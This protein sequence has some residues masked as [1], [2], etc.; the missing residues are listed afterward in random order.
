MFSGNISELK[1]KAYVYTGCRA[2]RPDEKIY[3]MCDRAIEE[4]DKIAQFQYQYVRFDAII[5]EL[6]KEP[7]RKFLQGAPWYYL[8]A[9]TLGETVDRRVHQLSVTDMA[10][11]VVFNA[12]A[13]AYLECMADEFEEKNLSGGPFF[14]FCPGYG[15]S[16]VTDLFLLK[17]YLPVEKIH[18]QVMDSGMLLP[19]KSM[20]GIVAP[21][22][23]ATRPDAVIEGKD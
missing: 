17:K 7:Y 12:V 9:M 11:M 13:A 21:K 6:D 20:I 1:K 18:I 3:S 16:S 19:E 10:Y 15:G 14:R 23:P 2:D 4:L 5:D 8:A 22:K